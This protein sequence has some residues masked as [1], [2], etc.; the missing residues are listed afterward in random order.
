MLCIALLFKSLKGATHKVLHVKDGPRG[1][2]KGNRCSRPGIL[3]RHGAFLLDRNRLRQF[4]VPSLLSVCPLR[5]YVNASV[6]PEDLRDEDFPCGPLTPAMYRALAE[7][8]GNS[9]QKEIAEPYDR[10]VSPPPEAIK[11]SEE[12]FAP[13]NPHHKALKPRPK[14]PHRRIP[15]R[16]FI[17]YRYHN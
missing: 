3:T 8:C 13:P 1:Y 2:Y 4:I 14:G 16:P 15:S 5:P 9:Y 6:L 11:A 7:N 12:N 17:P 10:M